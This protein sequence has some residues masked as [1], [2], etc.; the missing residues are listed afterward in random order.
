MR[1][2]WNARFK[3]RYRRV[4]KKIRYAFDERT[5]LF[6]QDRFSPI[7]NNHSLTGKWS[8]YRSINITGDWRAVFKMLDA[9]TA[10]FVEIGTHHELYDS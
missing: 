1:I 5:A 2:L 6:I 10:Y 8:G 7:L 4:D 3:R 9:D